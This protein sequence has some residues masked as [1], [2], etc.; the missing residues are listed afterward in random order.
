LAELIYSF[1]VYIK[2][3]WLLI[4]QSLNI[5]DDFYYFHQNLIIDF[6]AMAIFL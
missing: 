5:F 4:A 1:I 2:F 3:W 6:E